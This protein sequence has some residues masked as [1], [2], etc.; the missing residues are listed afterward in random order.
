MSSGSLGELKGDF[1][2]SFIDPIACDNGD[3]REFLIIGVGGR[4]HA[5]P[6]S[7][8]SGLYK[9]RLSA[10]APSRI[11]SFLGMLGIGGGIVPV[12]DLRTLIGIRDGGEPRWLFTVRGPDALGLAFDRFIGCV[13][14][15]RRMVIPDAVD[16][17][18]G[19]S[20]DHFEM[21]TLDGVAYQI[22]DLAPVLAAINTQIASHAGP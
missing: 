17:T 3:K 2:R 12:Y 15:S 4:I 19:V 20:S 13:S 10:P 6:L 8:V 21:V 18:P 11:A 14:V 22:L 5:L 1:Q 7:S 16:A 9:D